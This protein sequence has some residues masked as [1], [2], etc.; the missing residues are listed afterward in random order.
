MTTH[1]PPHDI[2]DLSFVK[3]KAKGRCFWHVRS[4]GD[5]CEDEK[6][7]QR[8][9]LEYLAYEEAD[10]S[11]PGHL[12]MIVADM[13]RKLGPIEISFLALVSYAAGAGAG[14]AR[15]VANYWQNCRT[16]RAA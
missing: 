7:G 16:Q 8:L 11:G 5:D 6:L 3:S 1:K 4:T 9:A 15:R 14:K 2:A 12:Q 13:P 10:A